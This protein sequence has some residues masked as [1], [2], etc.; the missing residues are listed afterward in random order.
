[1]RSSIATN[2]MRPPRRAIAGILLLTW[3][4]AASGGCASVRVSDPPRT[5]TEQFLLST[6][7]AE[8]VQQLSFEQ[9]RDRTV[10]VDTTYFAASDEAFVLG[11][12]RAR[13]LLAGV[14]IARDRETAQIILEVRSGGVGIDRY[15][16]LLGIP[17]VLLSPMAAQATASSGIP[18]A[19]PEV[20]ITKHTEQRG[21]AAVAFV[22]YWA[23]SGEVVASS[24]PFV[25][26]S[27]RDDWWFFG[28]GPKSVGDIPPIE[29]PAE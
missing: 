13:L 5:A 29:R 1:M 6:A 7:A 4:A 9:L 8:A 25:G 2:I 22:A 15:D 14:Q 3:L 21:V 26:R 23:D 12:L 28:W 16:S 27:L 19:T 24:G 17:S 18:L 20:A 11:E 10:Y